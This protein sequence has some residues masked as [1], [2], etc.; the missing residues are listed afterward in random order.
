M[1]IRKSRKKH[2]DLD[3]EKIINLNRTTGR[4]Y[5]NLPNKNRH[6]KDKNDKLAKIVTKRSNNRNCTKDD[7][8]GQLC[9]QCFSRFSRKCIRDDDDDDER[10]DENCRCKKCR[11]LMRAHMQTFNQ[12]EHYSAPPRRGSASTP[13]ASTSASRR[14]S[15]PRTST[16]ASSRRAPTPTPSA[17]TSASTSASSKYPPNKKITGYDKLPLYIKDAW[18]ELKTKKLD[19]EQLK[20]MHFGDFFLDFFYNFTTD[21]TDNQIE[22]FKEFLNNLPSASSPTPTTRGSPKYPPNENISGYNDHPQYITEAWE[23]LK[24]KKLDVEQVK[25]MDFGDFNKLTDL[26]LNNNDFNEFKQFLNKLPKSSRKKEKSKKKSKKKDG[27]KT[28]QQPLRRKKSK[29]QNSGKTQQVRRS[30]KKK[31]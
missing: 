21:L 1:V 2:F 24:T 10:F 27:G 28:Q 16:S 31:L 26:W 7:V 6:K 3:G 12:D 18:E 8:T 17:S 9:K 29:S 5:P 22:E 11:E 19:V 4:R 25:K 13:S 20:K 14:T 23:E 15:P 30:K